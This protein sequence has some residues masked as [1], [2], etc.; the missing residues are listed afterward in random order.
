MM[1]A[2]YQRTADRL[3]DACLFDVYPH[4]PACVIDFDLTEENFAAYQKAV[5]EGKVTADQLHK[6]VGNGP[7]LSKLIGVKIVTMFD[8]LG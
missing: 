3:V 4:S 2:T 5:R 6:A 8:L 1:K 7:E